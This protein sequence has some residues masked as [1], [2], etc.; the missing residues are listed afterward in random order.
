MLTIPG[1][2]GPGAGQ[3]AYRVQL[4]RATDGEQPPQAES[5]PVDSKLAAVFRGPL[6]WKHYWNVCERKVVVA[7]GSTARV[8]LINAREAEI[9]LSRDDQR[10]VSAFQQGQRVCRS[11]MP[12]GEG[13]T[14]IG[15]SRDAT[16]GWFIAV[17]RV[18]SEK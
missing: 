18:E 17:R 7:R 10:T 1:F 2:A 12:L 5:K 13:I 11:T 6:K 16:S 8:R 9:D 15:G 4:I 14:I 3:V